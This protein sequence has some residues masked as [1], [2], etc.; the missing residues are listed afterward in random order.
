MVEWKRPVSTICHCIKGDTRCLW[1][2]V[3][4][5]IVKNAHLSIC[6]LQHSYF[7]NIY[8]AAVVA[9]FFFL[10]FFFCTCSHA[11]S[12]ARH[13]DVTDSIKMAVS[14]ELFLWLLVIVV[15]M[16]VCLF[17][18][19]FYFTKNAPVLIFIFIVSLLSIGFMMLLWCCCQ[20]SSVID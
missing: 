20:Y 19:L 7:V 12:H 1:S 15:G 18:C 3:W 8:A 2:A 4:P 9:S 11:G 10:F 6:G 5:G 16:F 14:A 17:V 13:D